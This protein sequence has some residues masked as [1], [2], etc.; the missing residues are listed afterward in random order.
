VKFKAVYII[1]SITLLL[2]LGILVLLPSLTLGPSLTGSFGHMNWPLI[3]VWV[4]LF[5]GFNIFYFIYRRLFL[6][7][8]KEDWP[9]LVRYLE[10]KV[11]QKGNY[12]SRLVRLLTN[13][14]LVLSDPAA[15]MSLE[16]KAAIAKPS[17][18]DDNALVF[19]TARIL[20][21]DI[22]GA[23]RF[24]E[25]RKGTTKAGL[26]EWVRWYYGFSLLLDNRHE[27]AGEEFSLLARQSNDGIITALSSCFLA[28]TMARVLPEKRLEYLDIS[29]E[30]RARALKAFPKFENWRRE[31]SRLS[32]EIHAA[33][34]AKYTE[35][36]GQWLYKGKES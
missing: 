14:Y 16:N 30:G 35:E 9:A 18:V 24:F 34:L 1:F 28:E 6:L 27:E 11:I 2:F 15:V 23:V 13:S 17:L 32:T 26:K 5:S 12:S 22:S 4:F 3:L 21:K 29:S 7:L 31:V 33:A 36:T 25:T 10:D 20:G 8:E 19:G